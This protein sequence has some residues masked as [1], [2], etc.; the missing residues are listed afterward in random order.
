MSITLERIRERFARLA[1][2]ETSLRRFGE[3][4][5]NKAAPEFLEA[6]DRDGLFAMAVSGLSLLQG[7]GDRSVQVRVFNPS[8]PA[9]G[10]EGPYTV[11]MLALDNRPFIVDSVRAELRRQGFELYHL[12]HPIFSIERD[13]S[14]EITYL[15]DHQRKGTHEAFE[16][17]FVQ[18]Q[19]DERALQKL[20]QAVTEVLGD[21]I[22]ATDDYQALREQ[23]RRLGHYLRQLRQV[24]AQGYY[25]DRAEELEEFAAFLDWLDDDNF[26]YLGYRE[27]DILTHEEVPY[28]KL[29]EGSGLGI[30]RKTEGSAYRQPVPLTDISEGLRERVTGG[31]LLVVTKTNAES[32]VHRPARMDYIGVKKLTDSW[33][34]LGEQRL[35]GLFTSKALSTPVD[36]T[37]ILRHKLQQVLELDNAAPDSHDY[38]QITTIFNSMPRGELFWADAGSLHQEIR[39]IMGLEQERGVRLT[40]RPDPLARGLA[41]MVIMPR[42]RFNAAVRGKIQELLADKLQASHVEYQLAMGEDEAQVRFHFFL[43]TEMTHFEVDIK[44][45]EREV[46]EL[47]RSWDDHLLEALVSESGEVEGRELAE[48][49]QT[50]FDERYQADNSSRSAVRDIFNLERVADTYRVDLFNPV[51]GRREDGVTLLKIYHRSPGLVLSEVLPILENLGLK[52]LE[53]VSYQLVPGGEQGIDVFRVQDRSG[54]RLDI[55]RHRLRLIEALECLLRG[56]AENDRL[57]RLVLYASLTIRQ[58]LLLRAYQMYYAQLSAG[59]SRGYVATTLLNHPSIASQLHR[60]FATKFDPG[61]EGER[62]AELALIEEQLSEALVAVS[63]LSEDRVLRGLFNLMEATLRTNFFLERDHLSFKI[64]SADVLDMPDPRPMFEIAVMGPGLEGTHLRGG[65][66]ARGGVRWSDRPDDF[67]T[68]VLGLLKTQMTKNAVTVPV[69]SKGGFVLKRPPGDREALRGYVRTQYQ[70]FIRGLLDLTDNVLNGQTVPPEGVLCYDDPDPYLV[71]AADKGTAAFSDLAN[72]T[73]AEYRFW[74]GDAFASGGSQG[75]DHKAEGITARGTW[76][77]VGRHFREL[78]ADVFEDLITVVGIG[79]M[80]GDVFGNG[81]LFTDKIRLLAA[82]NHL[83]IFLDPD[84][85]PRVSYRERKRLFDLPRSSW[86]DYDRALISAGGGVFDRAAK[87]IPLGPQLK[88]LLGLENDA[89]SGQDL[90]HALLKMPVDL[91]WNGGVGTYVKAGSERHADVGDASNDAVRVGEGGNLGLTQLARVEYALAGGKINTDAI[92]NSAG[93]DMSDREVNLKILLQALV[94]AGELTEV[95]RNRLLKEMTSEVSSLVLRNNYHQSLALSSAERRSFEDLSLFVSLQEYLSERGGLR[96]RV[97]FLP[98][99]KQFLDRER[100]GQGL[101]RPELATLLSYV[102]QGLYRHLLKTSFPDDPRFQHYLTSYFPTGVRESFPEAIGAHP[103]RREIIATQFTNTVVDILGISFVH[104][105]INETGATPEEIIKAALVTLEILE[106]Q[107]FLEELFG[108]DGEVPTALQYRV[109]DKMVASVEAIANWMLLSD[110]T[111]EPVTDFVAFYRK[112]LRTLREDL[113]NLLPVPERKHYRSTVRRLARQGIPAHLA[114]D[115]ASFDYL[116]SGIG[117]VEASHNAG[118][119][120]KEVA[121]SYFA[122]G[123]R[124]GLGWL[125]D[126]LVALPSKDKWEKIAAGGLVI[127]LRRAQRNLTRRYLE[128]RKG[129]DNLS[130]KRFLEA[131]LDLYRYDQTLHEVRDREMLALASG[132]VLTRLLFRALELASVTSRPMAL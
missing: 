92:D 101:S 6:F 128:A 20:E 99:R 22:L 33:Q 132:E 54:K 111:I 98:T 83:H 130:L 47:I 48:R 76:E 15:D 17:Y 61:F 104:R 55:R 78:G 127:E 93:V 2:D 80:S 75:Y 65:R 121:K 21:V 97:E 124:L 123:E 62:S 94:D 64:S 74:L 122:L 51:G 40:L 96:P 14:G 71:V 42:D 26:V 4:L 12:L 91:L 107:T 11:L 63:S 115:V 86:Q 3:V 13:E 28:L 105:G 116:A 108:L 102:K 44:L 16:M 69:G 73:A 112:P 9:D 95:Q 109:L 60:Y 84:P 25:R 29:T 56:A 41:I 50:A 66:V 129:E 114:Q 18:K 32:S 89:L 126:G 30:L 110:L 70:T 90:I 120:L 43:T 46:A 59:T 68:E 24:S 77:C 31:R 131:E 57:N 106:A 87:S 39:T 100:A 82:F 27:Y 19:E 52:V 36:E 72:E 34:V 35:L 103:L 49:Y 45:I 5:F 81:M 118:A 113:V 67:R 85:D 8:F 119:E 10:W 1:S 23:G 37:P 125:R 58:V 117:V 79:D 7:R 38:K 53:Q 88:V